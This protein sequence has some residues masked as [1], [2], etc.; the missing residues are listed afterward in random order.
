MKENELKEIFNGIRNSSEE[1]F[2]KLYSKYNKLVYGIAFSIL[3]NGQDAEDVVQTVF[4]KIYDIDKS[5]LPTDKEAS[6][7][8]T[9]TKNES[10]TLLRKRNNHLELESIYEIEDENNEISEI[11]SQDSYNRIISKLNDKEKEIVSLKILAKLSFDEI[12]NLLNEPTG[13]I[14]WRY[15]KSIHTL[16]LLLSNLG[17]FIITFVIG[18]KTLFSQKVCNNIQQEISKDEI[19]EEDRLTSKV[20]NSVQESMREEENKGYNEENFDTD[21]LEEEQQGTI[22]QEPDKEMDVN[23]VGIGILSLSVV[24]LVATIIFSIINTKY[25]LKRKDRKK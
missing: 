4:A 16:K 2:E 13:T 10:I 17:M 5:K 24:F 20:E 1:S 21:G 18:I 25:Q 15:Y 3:K 6:W 19:I 11:I 14:K 22:I 12:A 7:L 23:Y 8:Y 9:T